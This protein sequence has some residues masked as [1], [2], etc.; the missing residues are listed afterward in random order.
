[1]RE[2]EDTLAILSL[3]WPAPCRVTLVGPGVRSVGFAL[4]PRAARP[5]RVVPDSFGTASGALITGTVSARGGRQQVLRSALRTGARLGGLRLLPH[6][7]QISCPPGAPSITQ[8]LAEALGTPVEVAV[9]LGPP[10]ANRKP[11]L[12]VV[13]RAGRTIAFA[14]VGTT[15]LT[16]SLVEAEGHGLDR[17]GAVS[18]RTLTIPRV[19]H[20]GT[21]AGLPVLVQSPVPAV[22]GA[23]VPPAHRDAALVELSRALGS[24]T[25]AVDD[26]A[27]L[28]ELDAA[29]TQASSRYAADLRARVQQLRSLSGA[30]VWELGTWHG[31]WTPWNMG[32]DG[33]RVALWD[34]ERM[35]SQVPVGLDALHL[36]TQQ[37]IRASADPLSAT[38]GVLARAEH[39]LRPWGLSRAATRLTS[40]AYLLLIGA[41]YA[42][43]GQE[44]T[45]ARLGRLDQWLIPALDEVLAELTS[46]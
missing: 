43:D 17:L 36:H 15:P 41:R 39:L 2:P 19:L 9:H 38:L 26:S 45:G 35:R 29:L 28:G 46:P 44:D 34:W 13:D 22:S 24:D 6:R 18:L 27:V 42:A 7:V 20:R 12:Q 14:K 23:A 1:M 3:L 25:V 4:L 37:A 11:V 8:H 31:D 21:F 5:T 40:A 10:R 32:P 33:D 16:S 30:E